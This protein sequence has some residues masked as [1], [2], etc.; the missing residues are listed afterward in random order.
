MVDEDNDQALDVKQES[1]E[2]EEENENV[3]VNDN[4]HDTFNKNDYSNYLSPHG[5]RLYMSSSF[6]SSQND[7]KS[8]GNDVTYWSPDTI[9][10]NGGT[11]ASFG[12]VGDM[13]PAH[14]LRLGSD[15]SFQFRQR[16]GSESSYQNQ[17]NPGSALHT[18]GERGGVGNA[19]IR[20]DSSGS[21]YSIGSNTSPRNRFGHNVFYDS[22]A[23]NGSLIFQKPGGSLA[24]SVVPSRHWRQPSD[25]SVLSFD[26]TTDPYLYGDAPPH[27][28]SNNTYSETHQ[29]NYN[30]YPSLLNPSS[31][32]QT[33]HV[34]N[35]SEGNRLDQSHLPYHQRKML[36]ANTQDDPILISMEDESQ[37][38][39][40]DTKRKSST[41]FNNV[42]KSDK[43]STLKMN[44]EKEN[45]EQQSTQFSQKS[46][47]S[48]NKSPQKASKL[49][50]QKSG[51]NTNNNN[52]KGAT[53]SAQFR[54]KRPPQLNT[55]SP[56]IHNS[57]NPLSNA[58]LPGPG[59][60]Q[61]GG[62]SNMSP[63]LNY[64]LPRVANH[65]QLAWF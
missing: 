38:S 46:H 59:P 33:S 55:I 61:T 48:K 58:S 65:G 57:E 17:Y 14:R 52:T 39:N 25:T 18:I 13:V 15:N 7:S 47:R 54:S 9:G 43:N 22:D 53:T 23:S 4:L 2:E 41:K 12:Q 49:T 28:T 6:S 11:E 8:K 1:E 37:P 34:S 29:D 27:S 19:R 10:E 5:S 42:D 36:R 3:D 35:Q 16:L 20:L 31:K 64:P 40:S 51:N 32:R 60:G 24:G 30:P 45:K 56:L 26:S 62:L 44:E 21:G 63:R 50:K